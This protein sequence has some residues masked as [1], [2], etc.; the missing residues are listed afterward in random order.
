MFNLQKI[1]QNAESLGQENDKMKERKKNVNPCLSS[2]LLS[3]R[4]TENGLARILNVLD[5]NMKN[6]A[7]FKNMTPGLPS[8]EIKNEIVLSC[9]A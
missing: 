6:R 3:A 1:A 8:L 9:E 4:F 5:K 7:K 2:P